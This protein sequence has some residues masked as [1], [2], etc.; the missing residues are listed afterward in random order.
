M[1]TLGIS[2]AKVENAIVYYL[3]AKLTD[4]ALKNSDSISPKMNLDM[5]IVQIMKKYT[6][7][8]ML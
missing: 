6:K 3:S 7:I 1:S 4:D 2:S 8:A 5:A